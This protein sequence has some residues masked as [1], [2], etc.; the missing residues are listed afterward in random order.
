[1][2]KLK[3]KVIDRLAVLVDDNTVTPQNRIEFD[4]LKHLLEIIINEP[5]H[6]IKARYQE[7]F[8][9]GVDKR[10]KAKEEHK[11]AMEAIKNV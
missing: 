4:R 9:Q 5:E 1:M 10:I 8:K 6:S 11:Q 3:Q 2:D 7:K